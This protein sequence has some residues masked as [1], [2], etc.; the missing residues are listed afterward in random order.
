MQQ[1]DHSLDCLTVDYVVLNQS[2]LGIPPIIEENVD[3][4]H[5]LVKAGKVRY[6]GASAMYA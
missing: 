5:N 6:L 2:T 1:I 4:L 3:A